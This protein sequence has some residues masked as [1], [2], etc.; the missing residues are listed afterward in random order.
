[1]IHIL[2]KSSPGFLALLGLILHTSLH[3]DATCS[4]PA[5][6]PTSEFLY[7]GRVK[8]GTAKRFGTKTCDWLS[9]QTPFRRNKICDGAVFPGGA[10]NVCPITCGKFYSF[11]TKEEL[12]EAVNVYCNDPEAW[13]GSVGYDMYGPIETWD[14]SQMTSLSYLFKDQ[15]ECN[16]AIGSWEVGQAT[17]LNGLFF[18]ASSFNQDLS[19]W[20]VS[21]NGVFATMFFYAKQFNSDISGWDVSKG[22][23]FSSMFN[24]AKSFNQDIGSWDV[25]TST[26][27]QY[28]FKQADNFDQDISLWDVSSSTDFRAMFHYAISFDQDLCDWEIM[29]GA[30][31]TF[32]CTG[33]P[34]CGDCPFSA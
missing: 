6:D 28:M 2:S 16:P 9:L 29:P 13:K 25:S 32:F 8:K 5:D 21:N 24:N 3:V 7:W 27:F 17:N 14:V 18:N 31:T 1:M 26:D 22:R 15:A 23:L 33:A 11:S 12:Q 20:D 4:G 30:D 34:S 19:C 10:R